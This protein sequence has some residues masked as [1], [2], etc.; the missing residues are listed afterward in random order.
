MSKRSIRKLRHR[1]D[2][3]QMVASG[4]SPKEV[5][6]G[7]G[8]LQKRN[9]M[10]LI[11]GSSPKSISKNIAAERQAGKPQAQAV[12]IAEREADEAKRK[13]HEHVKKHEAKR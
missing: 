6:Q 4:L 5:A 3:K 13:H 10:P 12:A 8:A 7:F 1:E 9:L 11:K 2:F